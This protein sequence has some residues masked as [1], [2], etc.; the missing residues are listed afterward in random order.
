MYSLTVWQIW[1]DVLKETEV[2]LPDQQV[3]YSHRPNQVAELKVRVK[4][5]KLASVWRTCLLRWLKEYFWKWR[6]SHYRLNNSNYHILKMLNT[7][8][9]IY[10]IECFGIFTNRIGFVISRI[11][12]YSDFFKIRPFNSIFITLKISFGPKAINHQSY[13]NWRFLTWSLWLW[14]MGLIDLVVPRVYYRGF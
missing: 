6:V 10:S 14:V 8:L 12:V 9:C 13:L 1:Q 2:T 5:S 4:F 7:Y 11:R 3:C